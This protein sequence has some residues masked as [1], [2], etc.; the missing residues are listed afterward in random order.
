MPEKRFK[1]FFNSFIANDESFTLE[2]RLLISTIIIGIFVSLLGSV[3][4]IIISSSLAT[5][6]TA[7]SVTVVLIIFYFFVSVRKIFKPFVFPVIV[8]SFTGISIIWIFDGGINGSDTLIAFVILILALIIVPENRRKI[9]ISFFIASTV[10]IYLI[11]LYRPDLITQFPSEKTR[12]NDSLITAIYSSFFIFLIIQFLLK[13]YT[14]E[15][16]RALENE[17]KFRALAEN[18]Q[19]TIARFDLHHRYTYINKAGVDEM[20]MDLKKIYGKKPEETGFYNENQSLLLK[21]GIDK[22]LTT[23]MPQF[24]QYTIDNRNGLSYYDL[25]L[26]PEFNDKNEV[27]SV[28][29]VS[30]DI[31]NLK[32]SE[33]KLL[34]LNADKDLFISILAHDLKNPFFNIQGLSDLILEELPEMDMIS[35]EKKI[36][37]ISLIS[38]STFSMLEEL[39]L[40]TRSQSGKIEYNPKNIDF[41]KT[42]KSVVENMKAGAGQKDISIICSEPGEIIVP[43]DEE[44]LK[45]VLINL[46]SNAVK[47]TNRGGKV[48]ISLEQTSEFITVSVSDNGVGIPDEI[49]TNLFD[50]S[51][52]I[53]TSGTMN[54][55]GTGLGLLLCKEF[56]EKHGGTIWAES[57]EG[58]GSRFKFTLPTHHVFKSQ[59]NYSD[60]HSGL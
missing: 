2:N 45:I 13:N 46:I 9:V 7:I 5:I 30:R 6:L 54:E 10:V 31:T 48:E 60:N 35:L 36:K 55:K 41:V 57:K 11:Q 1:N 3:V 26:F 15:K 14:I 37:I 20:G 52:K 40:W 50:I 16:K 59:N 51:H 4:S 47:F 43:A 24:E 49:L 56:V 53:S 12:W 42:C 27:V 38:Q 18:S 28:L 44:L 8:V 34:R 25:R 32:Q 19:D 17:I 23:G 33:I 22:V 29:G 39:L 58:H 21:A